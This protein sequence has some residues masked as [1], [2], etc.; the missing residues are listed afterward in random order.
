MLRLGVDFLGG[1]ESAGGDPV[2]C[3]VGVFWPAIVFAL[4]ELIETA[5]WICDLSL[6]ARDVHVTRSR[7]DPG[8]GGN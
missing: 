6:E 7:K 5:T 4:V 1:L 2:E 8:R 3:W